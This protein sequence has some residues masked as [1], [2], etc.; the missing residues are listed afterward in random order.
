M[1]GVRAHMQKHAALIKP[2]F[3]KVLEILE[4]ELA[5]TGVAAWT[6][7]NGGYFISLDTAKGCA[8]AVVKMAGE[9]GVKLTGAG[10]TYPHKKDPNDANIRLAPTL[11]S[12]PEIAAAT[13]VVA[14]CVQIVAIQKLLP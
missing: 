13:E 8:A 5:G 10:A 11:P 12:P 4:N 3:D 1:N 14:V 2:K 6:S 7:P 9:A